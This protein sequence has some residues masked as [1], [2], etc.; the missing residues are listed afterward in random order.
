MFDRRVTKSKAGIMIFEKGQL[1]QVYNNKL[2]LT[3]STEHKLTPLWSPPCRVA[4]HLLN[5]YRL[6]TLEGTLLDG[7]FN[8]RRLQGFQLR[9]VM[10]LAM[11]QKEDEGNLVSQAS[12]VVELDE[13]GVVVPVEG[14]R[15]G[16]ADDDLGGGRKVAEEDLEESDWE[17]QE[18]E[19]QVDNGDSGAGFLYDDEEEEEQGNEDMGI[20]ARV[21]ARRRGCLH[22]RGGQME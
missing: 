2:A 20:G 6:K 21:A 10:K 7:L 14:E 22:N 12:G 9:E 16:V 4:E 11:Q 17:D 1:V 18:L 13:A 3:L 8:T 19:V 15:E 5:S